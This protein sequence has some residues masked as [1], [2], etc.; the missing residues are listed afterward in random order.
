VTRAPDTVA[1]PDTTL[2]FQYRLPD[3]TS[4]VS[5]PLQLTVQSD[6]IAGGVSPN[7]AGWLVRWRIV[8]DGDTL[9]PTDTTR[10]AL[11]STSGSR[12]TLRDTTTTEGTSTRRL[13]VYA[14]LLP[15]Q[16]DSFVVVAEVRYLGLQVPGSP[17][18]FVVNLT[19][20]TL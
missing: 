8:Y 15:V 3:A 5:P 9:S 1:A 16:P 18:R 2:N 19:P 10:V 17:V 11:W 14:N 12:H 20:P 6:D 13:R 7:V 4:N